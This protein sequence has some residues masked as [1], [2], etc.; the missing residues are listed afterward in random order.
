MSRRLLIDFLMNNDTIQYY[1]IYIK[2]YLNALKVIV[3]I[4]L[5][6]QFKIFIFDNLGNYYFYSRNYPSRDYPSCDVL[7]N[8]AYL[9]RFKI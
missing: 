1:I 9:I 5:I 4:P 7:L 3:V 6:F 2:L 8:M